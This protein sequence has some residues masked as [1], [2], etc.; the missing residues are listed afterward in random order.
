MSKET[1]GKQQDGNGNELKEAGGE[2]VQADGEEEAEQPGMLCHQ[3]Q[4]NQSSSKD[5]EDQ[6][7]G[8]V[9]LKAGDGNE[10]KL[11]G[12]WMNWAEELE[13]KMAVQR[14]ARRTFKS[15]KVLGF[16]LGG[17]DAIRA[18]KERY[19][20]TI[21]SWDEVGRM[22]A[23]LRGEG[24]LPVKL[25]YGSGLRQ[26]E[27]MRLRVKD[28]DFDRRIL[29]VKRGKGNKDRNVML[30]EAVIPELQRQR[31]AVSILWEQDKRAGVAGVHMPEALDRKY[32]CA[33]QELA[34][35]WLFPASKLSE[36]PATEVIRRFHLHAST[37]ERALH[38]AVREA[39]IDK[40]ITSHSLRHT[41]A[42]HL[43]ERGTDIHTVQK[44]LGHKSLETT[45]I[46]LHLAESGAAGAL[47]PL[48]R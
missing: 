10:S 19:L 32:P 22:F 30:P 40:H 5:A 6:A 46:Y 39:G 18:R 47:S 35:Q 24:A 26:S 23:V 16:E 43:V 13:K 15:K 38:R 2:K 27:A 21:L 9:I 34:W 1:S 11:A 20:P 14:Y 4:V 42:T 36:D 3:F 29:S 28:V 12:G 37:L 25:L 33:G 44:L 17:V 48:D 7:V 8:G 31:E 41:F 45:E